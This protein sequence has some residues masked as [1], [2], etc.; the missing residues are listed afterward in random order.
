MA[1]LLCRF[2]LPPIELVEDDANVSVLPLSA[3][4]LEVA[5]E[6]ALA[7]EAPSV[8]YAC[9]ADFA[10][11]RCRRPLRRIESV[12]GIMEDYPEGAAIPLR[13]RSFSTSMESS[14]SDCHCRAPHREWTR[15]PLKTTPI[16]AK[17]VLNLSWVDLRA[18]QVELPTRAS[19]CHFLRSLL[20]TDHGYSP[21][22]AA[23]VTTDA[24]LLYLSSTPDTLLDFR[25]SDASPSWYLQSIVRLARDPWHYSD[26]TKQYTLLVYRR[27]P[28]RDGV[29]C[30][31]PESLEGSP[32]TG[33]LWETYR[34]SE[35]D[36]T[37]P[38]AYRLVA[39]PYCEASKE[40]TSL[41]D[42]LSTPPA[43]A[44]L[45]KEAQSISHWTAWPETAHYSATDGSETPWTVFPLCYTFPA[46]TVE[47]RIWI[48][49]TCAL[50]PATVTMLQQI[51]P[52]LRTAL[53][54]RLE[55]DAV[56]EA[57]TGWQDL[58]NHVLRLHIPLIAAGGGLCGTWVDGCVET[59]QVGRI[60]CF[61]DSKTHWAFNY[62]ASDRIVLIID[63]ERPQDL[64]RGTAKGGHS[65]ELDQFIAKMG[66]G[67]V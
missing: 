9:K 4:S 63:L 36:P 64:P 50:V 23:T 27:L 14:H 56:L 48:P 38:M 1:T 5:L 57:H 42:H 60:L 67:G 37:A 17:S 66:V 26:R 45:Q 65:E 3:A 52:Q 34:D 43:L 25:V 13:W 53:F 32:V 51:G 58:A 31:H 47:K 28:P 39:P 21:W 44:T 15:T 62:S 19:V 20:G 35:E 18:S 61:D 29:T 2:D 12:T 41:L 8:L 6:N 40:Y 33:C 24:V 49:M 10:W 11:L 30:L 7:N 55:P 22:D 16:P 59:H 54:S 46:D